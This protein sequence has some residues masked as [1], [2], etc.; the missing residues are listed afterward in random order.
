MSGKETV[1]IIGAGPCGLAAGLA[2]QE[3]GYDPL[4]IEKGNVVHTIY[5]YPAH[6]TFF[7]SSE[8]LEIG[9]IPFPSI[10]R[11]PKRHEA[12]VYYRKTAERS[13]LRI[14]AYEEVTGVTKR[15]NDFLL[16]SKTMHGEE[17]EYTACFIVMATGYYDNPN[18][19]GVEGE[20]LPHVF[21]YFKESHPFFQKKVTIIGGKNSAVDAAL[22]LEQAGAEVTV[23]YRGH[24]FSNAVKPWILPNFHSL[25]RRELVTMRYGAEVTK[26]TPERVHYQH[27]GKLR[28]VKADFVFAMTGYHPDHSLLQRVGV[29]VEEETG[30]PFFNKETMESNV[31]GLF[32]AG[33]IAAGNEANEIFIENGRFHGE[34]IADAIAARC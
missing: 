31:E 6:Q 2:L 9:G 21:H 4:I 25:V 13:K 29:Q 11:K 5:R 10:E 17:K 30:R 24:E 27:Q 16:C 8:K 19:L 12:L 23:L 18:Y 3:K 7:S 22:A 20:N 26:I 33:V 34:Q 15:E 1:I 14:H 28:E 32:I